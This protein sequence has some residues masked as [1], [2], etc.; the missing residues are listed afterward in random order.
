MISIF[1]Y[2]RPSSPVKLQ[3]CSRPHETNIEYGLEIKGNA[4]SRAKSIT[5]GGGVFPL[6]KTTAPTPATIAVR[7][8]WIVVSPVN[9]IDPSDNPANM[10]LIKSLAPQVSISFSKRSSPVRTFA[11]RALTICDNF[12][13]SVQHTVPAKFREPERVRKRLGVH[14]F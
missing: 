8:T 7:I 14:R 2:R 10:S 13:C 6:T 9:R 5:S 4:C 11:S 3:A 1:F 12:I